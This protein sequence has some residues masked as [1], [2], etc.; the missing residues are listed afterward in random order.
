[1]DINIA[2][3][4][5]LTNNSCV[6]L[7]IEFLKYIL[8]QKQQIPFACDSLAQLQMKPTDRNL[9][10]IK[11]VLNSLKN[12]TEQLNSQF[13]LEGCKI[14][15][16][17]ILIGATI[18]TPKLHIRVEFPSNILS[19]QEHFECKHT[20]RKPLLS[21]MR[22]MLECSE[23]QDALNSP[24]NPTNTFVLIQK[25]DSNSMSEFFLPKPQYIPSKHTT[26]YFV[27]KLKY[28]DEIKIDCNC[29]DIVKIYNEESETYTNG[30]DI[31]FL[32]NSSVNIP[33]APYQWYQSK[34]VIK[35][36]KFLR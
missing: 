4:E 28:K 11:T 10:S 26:N 16:I 36:F 23:F 21:L 14:K 3:D 29:A 15:E 2:L 5:P 32:N 20:S 13:E 6:K 27:L 9:S 25:S 17:A 1:M 19:S 30:E 35:G 8:Y 12:T 18:I 33:H 7:V 31:G 34:E 22:S 24:L